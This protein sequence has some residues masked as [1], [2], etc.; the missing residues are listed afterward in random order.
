MGRS[1]KEIHARHESKP[2]SEFRK[3]GAGVGKHQIWV[4]PGL[5]PLFAWQWP[6]SAQLE[7]DV[8]AGIVALVLDF[9]F[10]AV[11]RLA[12]SRGQWAGLN[13]Q[14]APSWSCGR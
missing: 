10:R 13:L 1:C 7:P 6:L 3:P 4:V 8:D 5:A 12:P 9:G 11:P 2:R 14:A